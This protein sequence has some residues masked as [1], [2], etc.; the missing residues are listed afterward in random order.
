MEHEQKLQWSLGCVQQFELGSKETIAIILGNNVILK[1]L[2]NN[3][4]TYDN[5][6]SSDD[7]NL[8]AE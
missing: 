8:T 2:M 3:L 6:D 5:I 1:D 7:E 4:K